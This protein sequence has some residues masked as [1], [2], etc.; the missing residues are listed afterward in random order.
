M[1]FLQKINN[2]VIV[3]TMLKATKKNLIVLMIICIIDDKKN[4]ALFLRERERER[5]GHINNEMPSL[6]LHTRYKSVV[7]TKNK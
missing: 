4:H 1:W 6:L 5:D 7:V 3:T 2:I